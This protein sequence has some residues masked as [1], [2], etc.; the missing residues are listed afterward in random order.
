M[1][2]NEFQQWVKEYY[3]ARGWSDLDIFIRIGFLAEET[4]EVARAIRALEIGRDRPDEVDGTY[5]EQKQELAEE[6]GDVLGNLIVI[7]NKYEIPLEDIFKAHR[8]KLSERY[9][10]KK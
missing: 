4:G 9:A 3:E 8:N 1:N 10:L 2:V 5:T 7:A 6:L